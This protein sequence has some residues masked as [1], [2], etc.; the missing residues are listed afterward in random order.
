MVGRSSDLALRR[1]S[2]SAGSR[3]GGYGIRGPPMSVCWIPTTATDSVPLFQSLLN[4]TLLQFMWA[5]RLQCGML[6]GMVLTSLV[7]LTTAPQTM[8][9][10][11]VEESL[12]L[13]APTDD[14]CTSDLQDSEGHS[15]CTDYFREPCS[16]HTNL[17]LSADIGLII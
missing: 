4:R 17:Y 5:L 9:K 13:S 14:S 8:S 1:G 2:V 7:L 3:P 11:D 10:S 15:C 12:T 6:V 16:R